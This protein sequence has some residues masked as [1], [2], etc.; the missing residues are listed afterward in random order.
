MLVSQSMSRIGPEEVERIADL[1]R[2][3]LSDA[4]VAAAVRDLD[5]ILDYVAELEAVDT[6][7]IEPTVHVIPL[8]TPV[9]EDRAS[10]DFD[11]ELAL[12]GVPERSGTAF[13]VP[14]V[15]EGEEEG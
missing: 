8:D 6:E 14:K 12:A 15:I 10:S 13:V 7:G 9:R 11:P 1:A 2:L 5:R 4:E 3:A